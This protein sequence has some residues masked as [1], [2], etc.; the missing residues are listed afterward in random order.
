LWY[1]GAVRIL[2]DYRPALRERTGVGEYVHE[3]ARALANSTEDVELSIFSASW[4]DRPSADLSRQLDGARVIDRRLPVRGLNWAWHRLG[5][6]PVEWVA[7]SADV[8]HAQSP[9]LIPARRAAQVVTIHDLDFLHHPD[10]TVG[11]MRR[12]YPRL[13]RDHARRADHIVVSSQY[14]AGEVIAHL[15]VPPEKVSICSPGAPDWAHPLERP[16]PRRGNILFIGT[17]ERRKNVSG[18]I[19]AYGLLRRQHPDAPPLVLAGRIRPG[20]E[21]ELQR[22]SQQPVS[23]HVSVL[24]YVSEAKRRALFQD[25]VMLVLPS[26]EEGFGLPVLEAMACGLP[27]VVSDRGSLPEVAGTAA[28]PVDPTDIEGLAAA[29]AQLLQPDVSARARARGYE[30]AARYSWAACAAATLQ[31]YRAAIGAR[32]ERSR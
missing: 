20:A 11:E 7:G 17:I 29:M 16:I 22:A 2:L 1:F 30:E 8:V 5:W 10:R 12:D 27:V 14:A 18:L 19:D 15:E 3:L 4:K 25:A 13:V 24:G 23:G 31:A 21:S 28:T 26:F 9:M 6:P 32:A